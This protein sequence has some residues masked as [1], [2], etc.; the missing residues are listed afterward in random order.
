MRVNL[1]KAFTLVELLVVIAIIGVLVGLLLPA[2]QYAREAARRMQ[3]SNNLR[4]FGIAA[5]GYEAQHN[6]LPAAR[7]YSFPDWAT[8]PP[9]YPPNTPMS[10]IGVKITRGWSY[11]LLP[12]IEQQSL[13]DLLKRNPEDTQANTVKVPILLCPSDS[14]NQHATSMSYAANGGCPNRQLDNVFPASPL[15]YNVNPMGDS[16]S[17][18]V[19]DDLAGGWPGLRATSANCKDGSSQTFL[20]IE[21][22]NVGRWNE[23]FYQ[24]HYKTHE[25]FQCVNWVPCGP[26]NFPQAFHS[27]LY[28][29]GLWAINE[30]GKD[31]LDPFHARPSSDHAAGF[32]VVFLGGN[33]RYIAE[34][35]EYSV[36]ARLMTCNGS[37]TSNPSNPNSDQYMS[38]T[39]ATIRQ[40]QTQLVQPQSY[41]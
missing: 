10:E 1:R 21:N 41:E 25:H 33:T 27:P 7:H 15:P 26:S 9:P 30:G 4:Q 23:E 40:W 12:G 20:Y 17:N 3:C 36:Y 34:S 8:V 6:K 38:A 19:L 11:D 14:T 39:T 5:I 18:G 29:G 24:H 22:I 35:I 37:R 31:T 16:S 13:Y 32:Q 28:G 2:V